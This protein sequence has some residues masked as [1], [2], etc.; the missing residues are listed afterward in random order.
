MRLKQIL[1]NLVKNALKFCR[2]GLIHII[3]AYDQAEQMLKVLVIDTGK[4]I[5]AEDLDRLFKKFGKLLRTAEMNSEGIGMGLMI[6]QNIV[7]KSGGSISV[8]S[9]GEDKGATFAFS[10]HMEQVFKLPEVPETRPRLQGSFLKRK[11]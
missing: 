7:L 3:M 11:M 1:I 9:K 6:C 10:M 2:R 8:H 5:S 4:G